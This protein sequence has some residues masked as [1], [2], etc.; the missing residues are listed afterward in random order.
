[1][2]EEKKMN[3]EML[4]GADLKDIMAAKAEPVDNEELEATAGGGTG[5][6]FSGAGTGK[7]P[8]PKRP[9]EPVRPTRYRIWRAAVSI[10]DDVPGSYL[11]LRS[12][13]SSNNAYEIPGIRITAGTVFN[14]DPNETSGNFIYAKYNGVE[15]WVTKRFARL[16]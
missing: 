3:E 11:A 7:K 1:M 15:G 9:E 14:V 4:N 13:P 12:R 16:L 10:V 5:L 6:H 2:S 8:Q